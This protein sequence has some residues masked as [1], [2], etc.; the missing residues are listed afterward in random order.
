MRLL[1]GGKKN[2]ENGRG[3]LQSARSCDNVH[4]HQGLAG[5]IDASAMVGLPAKSVTTVLEPVEINEQ[6]R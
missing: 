2:P 3:S 5:C 1:K 6:K 4:V